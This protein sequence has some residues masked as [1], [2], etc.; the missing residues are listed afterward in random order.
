V[1]SVTFQRAGSVSITPLRAAYE[2]EVMGGGKAVNVRF[3][4]GKG[5]IL[6]TS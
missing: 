6:F 5:S 4:K 3:L 2:I 1:K